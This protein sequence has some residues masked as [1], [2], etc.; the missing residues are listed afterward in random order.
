MARN[1]KHRRGAEG[2]DVPP[3]EALREQ[4]AE[5]GAATVAITPTY[6]HVTIT[7]LENAPAVFI[8]PVSLSESPD[9]YPAPRGPTLGD[10]LVIFRAADLPAHHCPLASVNGLRD[11][12]AVEYPGARWLVEV[13]QYRLRG[14]RPDWEADGQALE[15]LVRHW[16]RGR[17]ARR[18]PEGRVVFSLRAHD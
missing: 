1:K 9:P 2:E 12:L 7:P 6:E 11:R 4:V 14:P 17:R 10:R 8:T 5:D 16:E 13:I 3:T 15:L 18:L